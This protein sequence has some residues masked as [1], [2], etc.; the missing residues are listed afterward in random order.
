M[1]AGR[2][3]SHQCTVI[4]LLLLIRQNSLKGFKKRNEEL[5]IFW[6]IQWCIPLLKPGSVI[7]PNLWAGGCVSAAAGAFQGPSGRC[8]QAPAQHHSC[9]VAVRSFQTIEDV[10]FRQVSVSL[11]ELQSGVLN[12]LHFF[13]LIPS[14][15]QPPDLGASSPCPVCTCHCC[16]KGQG[17]VWGHCS[18]GRDR[19]CLCQWCCSSD[20]GTF[21]LAQAEP[22]PALLGLPEL[23]GDVCSPVQQLLC[24]G[25]L[26]FRV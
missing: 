11:Q 22:S 10:Y 23:R 21:L 2:M 6:V 15:G 16:E 5:W 19:S 20:S 14:L 12:Y 9:S 13:L 26:Y 25:W 4:F 3:H 8:V 1:N 17:H 18:L 7:A 24:Q